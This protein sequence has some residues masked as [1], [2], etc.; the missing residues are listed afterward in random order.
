MYITVLQTNIVWE[1]KSKN[2]KNLEDYLKLLSGKTEIVI[3]PEMFSTG[4]SM[5]CAGLAEAIDDFTI[6]SLKVLSKNYNIAL[7]GSYMA[8]DTNSYYN[9]AF[10]ITPNG[11]VSYYDKRH[12]F[13]MGDESKYFSSGNNNLI[14]TYNDFN[15]QLLICYDLRFPVWSRLN[16]E[17]PYDMLIYV[18]NWP[19]S[20]RKVWDTLL[21]ARALENQ[22]YVCGVNRVGDDGLGLHYDGGSVIISPKGEIM[23]TVKD[24]E[25]D[26][27]SS[28]IDLESLKHFRMK[29][30]VW[31]DA[32]DFKLN[33]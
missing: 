30:P 1:N 29:F 27:A 5:N 4:F 7:V 6:S 19:A 9:R 15:I 20:R 16:K 21:Q 23:N 17:N 10:F 3:L 22:C 18:A 12:L 26:Y 24:D 8:K 14:V 32:D 11:N 25:E 31:K 13:R 33:I 2:L 28:S